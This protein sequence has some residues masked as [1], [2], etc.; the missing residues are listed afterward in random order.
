MFFRGPHTARQKK[1][2]RGVF[3]ASLVILLA[4]CALLVALA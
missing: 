4:W 1:Y 3:F 2:A